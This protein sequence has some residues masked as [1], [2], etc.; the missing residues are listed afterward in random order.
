MDTRT[1]RFFTGG[2]AY[3]L[4]VR[5]CSSSYIECVWLIPSFLGYRLSGYD[6]NK[7]PALGR[8]CEGRVTY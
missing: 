2:M 8:D 5:V 1:E 3:E 4:R 6:K 7:T